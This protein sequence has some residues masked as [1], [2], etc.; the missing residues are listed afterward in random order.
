MAPIYGQG[1]IPVYW[2]ANLIDGQV[3]VYS[4]PDRRVTPRT[5]CSRRGMSCPWYSMAS[6]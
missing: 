6:R 4:D 2:I 1:G 5:K 3:E